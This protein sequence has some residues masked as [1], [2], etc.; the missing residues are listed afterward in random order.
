MFSLCSASLM[1]AE[2]SSRQDW[3]DFLIVAADEPAL[4]YPSRQAAELDLEVIDVEN[5]VYPAAYGPAGE[6]YRVSV[7]GKNVIIEPLGGPNK[8]DE[9][10]ALLLQY[11]EAI[12]EPADP[13]EELSSMVERVRRRE[14][15]FWAEN[16]PFGE[17]FSPRTSA[18][19]CFVL[20]AAIAAGAYFLIF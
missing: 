12:G 8:P 18:W 17:R 9:L 10:K 2:T 15:D 11:Y 3:N 4:F 16:D 7:S 13:A 5:G 6:P 14:E 20:F 19:S 1:G